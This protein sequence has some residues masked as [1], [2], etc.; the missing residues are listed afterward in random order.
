MLEWIARVWM[1][2]ELGFETE[3]FLGWVQGL[4]T[5][6]QLP[7]NR[8][9]ELPGLVCIGLVEGRAFRGLAAWFWIRVK[10]CLGLS[11]VTKR[12]ITTCEEEKQMALAPDITPVVALVASSDDF[13]LPVLVIL[14]GKVGTL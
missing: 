7:E 11:A 12:D 14:K 2:I 5:P 3:R 8:C 4:I 6:Q 9:K 1:F 13:H 10:R